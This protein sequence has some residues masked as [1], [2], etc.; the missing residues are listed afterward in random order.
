MKKRVLS[1]ILLSLLCITFVL[2]LASCGKD[3]GIEGVEINAHKNSSTYNAMTQLYDVSVSVNMQNS[4]PDAAVCGFDYRIDFYD[5]NGARIAS[6][7][8]EYNY[9]LDKEHSDSLVVKL[10][11]SNGLMSDVAY[12]SAVPV[13]MELEN[14]NDGSW[15]FWHWFGLGVVIILGLLFVACV[16]GC[17]SSEEYIGIFGGAIIFAL[18]AIIILFLIF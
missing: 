4:N 1:L 16:F 14:V 7:T 8:F 10:E 11:G 3:K 5:G 15:G 9:T 17:V 13:S 12:V 18:P 2:S 6:R